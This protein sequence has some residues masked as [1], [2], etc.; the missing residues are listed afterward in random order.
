MAPPPVPVP[1]KVVTTRGDVDLA[2]ELFSVSA[3][4]SVAPSGE[5]DTQCFLLKRV[6]ADSRYCPTRAGEW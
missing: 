3:T 1:A 2:D 5:A 6:R 4:K